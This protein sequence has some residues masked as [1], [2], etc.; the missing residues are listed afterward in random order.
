MLRVSVDGSDSSVSAFAIRARLNSSTANVSVYGLGAM[1]LWMN[2][3]YSNPTFKIV[4]LDSIYAG[5]ELQLGLFDPGDATGLSRLEFT[6]ALASIDCEMRVRYDTGGTS[7][8]NT[9]GSFNPDGNWAGSSCGITSAT[10]GTSRI[11]NGDWI[12]L[13]FKVPADHSCTG[14]ACSAYVDYEFSN[15]PFDRTTWT[16]Q[17]NG[18][19]IHLEP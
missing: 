7:A 18:T 4:R 6:G 14:D 19:P 3:D 16:A 5:T 15:S 13:R 1:S 17:I 11:Y 9:D 12:D 10:N 2:E 8:W